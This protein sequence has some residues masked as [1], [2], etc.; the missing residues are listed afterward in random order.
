M[1][2][3]KIVSRVGSLA[4]AY[5]ISDMRL[6]RRGYLRIV[7]FAV[8]GSRHRSECLHRGSAVIVMPVDWERGI[9]YLITQPRPN[10]ALVRHAEAAE[11]LSPA[12]GLRPRESLWC[13]MRKR[14]RLSRGRRP[15]AG[16]PTR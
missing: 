2:E 5:V 11:A 9:V 3:G 16:V 6:E 10:K 4:E 1:S 14:Q 7:S 15:K 13:V 8:E 12:F